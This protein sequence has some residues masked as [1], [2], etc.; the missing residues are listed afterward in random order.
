[1]A[2]ININENENI[3]VNLNAQESTLNASLNNINYIPSYKEAEEERRANELVRISNENERIAYYEDIQQKVANGEFKGEKGDKGDPGSGGGIDDVTVNGTTAVTNNVAELTMPTNLINGSAY[4]SL[5]GV[6]AAQ[7]NESTY[8]MG[9]NAF[10]MGT[11][12]KA[13][14]NSAHATGSIT[15]ASGNS[16]HAEG[17]Y[18]KAKATAAH[19]EGSRTTAN[20]TGS[21]TE[22]FGTIASSNY[23]HVQGKYNIEDADN[24]YAHILGNGSSKD[25]SNA[26]TVDWE[27]NA[28]YQGA[29]KVGGTS[30]DDACELATK[31]EIPSIE[32]LATETYVKNEIANAQ[33][34]GEGGEIDLSGYVTKDELN[35]KVD[36][37]TGKSLI[38]DSEITR[39]ANVTNYDDTEIKNN[40]NNKADK[41]DIPTVPSN[42]S[43]FTN[44]A[45]Y[46]T[47]DNLK[48][49]NNES[50]LGNGNIEISGSGNVVV[51]NENEITDETL[52]YIDIDDT[53]SKIPEWYTGAEIIGTG[54]NINVPINGS[55]TGDFYFNTETGNVYKCIEA[56]TWNYISNLKGEDGALTKAD[57]IKIED[58]AN[59]FNS[60]NV[61][62][63]LEE[64]GMALENTPD[65][66]KNYA[67][68]LTW[69]SGYYASDTGKLTSNTNFI[70][71]SNYIDVI[72][73]QTFVVSNYM[74]TGDYTSFKGRGKFTN[75]NGD[76]IADITY[77]VVGGNATSF[78]VT[79]P[80]GATRM[81]LNAW[82]SSISS[83][84]NVTVRIIKYWLTPF[85][86]EN[87][88]IFGK[89]WVSFGDS[90]TFQN[91][92]QPYLAEKYHL[93][94]TN[95]GIGSTKLAGVAPSSSLPSFWYSERLST[96]EAENPDILTI[97]GG[98]N[99]LVDATITIGTEEEFE[100]A[101]A[102]K[103]KQTFIGAYSYIIE[104]LL[105]WKP[106][107]KIVI[108]GTTWAHMNGKDY[109]DVLTYTDYSNASKLVAQY[110]GLP[111][112][113]LH[114]EAGF[115]KFTMDD[116]PYNIYST[117]HIH[118]NAEG[119]KIIASLVDKV[120]SH[121]Y[122]FN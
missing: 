33:L 15:E 75:S 11:N 66:A 23:Q 21:H 50:I 85:S 64:I 51:D 103:D 87:K 58:S 55:N 92:W 14:G 7:E 81:Y 91:Q 34:G 94:H 63:V 83:G 40:L 82:Y 4:G 25:R 60:P 22:G 68:S 106:T 28:W 122:Y 44:D 116:S 47:G 117:D 31:S 104:T 32:G 54:E 67:E 95:L 110:Y 12:A 70:C 56:N 113:D 24:Q 59:Y 79:V 80:T 72:E 5:R 6:N 53:P 120:F 69:Q 73:G 109:S 115:N 101:I 16:A 13:S 93:I 108:L 9:E 57:D 52:I 65:T 84:S 20:S 29:V 119:G 38:A 8:L 121:L 107:L 37:E 18:T 112:V 71:S 48:T 118:P 61:E 88:Y 86:S 98:A 17:N 3:K 46:V 49:I 42:V 74:T 35:N 36:K 97:L 19:A 39:L 99:D 2:T 77:A 76:L 26:H 62:G 96:I 102:D 27:G 45:G 43:E 90:I 10:A 100:K 1:M 89:K 41:S 111:F 105:T 114:G 30:Y 78:Y